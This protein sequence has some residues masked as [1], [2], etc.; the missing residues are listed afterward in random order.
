VHA[1]AE[2]AYRW[3]LQA[4][5]GGKGVDPEL[6][7]PGFHESLAGAEG[8]ADQTTGVMH[9]GTAGGQIGVTGAHEHGT[10]LRCARQGG[11]LQ[12]RLRGLI[13]DAKV[14][15][16]I[17]VVAPPRRIGC[18]IR[19]ARHGEGPAIHRGDVA[20]RACEDDGMVWCDRIP[21]VTIRM[22]SFAQARLV[23]ATPT[24]PRPWRLDRH[25][26]V[27]RFL[28]GI[29]RLHPRRFAVDRH[30]AYAEAGQMTVCIDEAG[31]QRAAAQGDLSCAGT[32]Q[33]TNVGG[34][35]DGE[36][37]PATDGGRFD[38]VIPRIDGMDLAAGE[39]EL[40]CGPTVCSVLRLHGLIS[41][42]WVWPRGKPAELIT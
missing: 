25:A 40:R 35:A 4:I 31:Q 42:R 39:D 36:D 10:E 24:N 11:H 5:D 27:Y 34:A 3:M 32:C 20:A 33:G 38:D 26:L 21:I 18:L 15:A 22:P 8:R 37:T 2:H 41:R 23:V 19:N 7:P 6:Q 28:Q 17:P 14:S 30:H 12:R 13:G 1:S 16:T 9:T 29:D